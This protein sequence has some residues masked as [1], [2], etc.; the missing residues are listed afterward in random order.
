MKKIYAFFLFTAV[1]GGAIA[2]LKPRPQVPQSAQSVKVSKDAIYAN[3]AINS[4]SNNDS[5]L[6]APIP[7][8][9][10]QKNMTLWQQI[11]G[12]TNYDNQSNGSMEDRIIMD[13]NGMGHAAWMLSNE[14][15]TWSDRGTG[16]N[17]G[18]YT[19]WEVEPVDRIEDVRTGWVDLHKTANG[20]EFYVCHDGSGAPKFNSRPA[21]GT[22][23]WTLIDLPTT[24][25]QDFLW[26]RAAVDGNTIHV[27]ALSEPS[28][29]DAAALPVNNLDGNLVYWR[30]D[31]AGATWTV[32]DQ[33]FA[34]LDVSE[35]EGISS[36]SYAIDARDGVV[37]IGIFSRFHDTA[38]LK[39][40]DNGTSWT[41]TVISDFA[42]PGYIYDSLSDSNADGIADTLFTCDGTGALLID[43]AGVTHVFF[44]SNF[45]L[46]DT[47]DDTFYS[48]F[49]TFDLLYWNETYATDDVF[50]CATAQE[51]P[52]DD[53]ETFTIGSADE[54]SNY[55]R[56][57][58]GMPTITEDAD[59]V[60][61]IVY[62]GADEEYLGSQYYRHL[63]V[64][65]TEDSGASFVD[66]VE[67]TPDVDYE[68]LEFAYPSLV[69][70]DG[71]LHIVA[72]RDSE[73]GILVPEVA[74]GASTETNDI[75]YLAVTTDLNVDVNVDEN[76]APVAKMNVYPSPTT[77]VVNLEGENLD[78]QSLK[79]Y[80]MTGKLMVNTTING[81]DKV[82]YD[83]SFLP[84]G[85]Y[86]L[87]IGSGK[88]KMST[89]ILIQ[90]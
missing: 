25:T 19:N 39:S 54:V 58:A 71:V 69:E 75:I 68:Y 24:F 3:P 50:I 38:L 45:I 80:D 40:G 64:T 81:R 2:Q 26:P 44:G 83:F 28:G 61:Y 27:I 55:T 48:Y 4:P 1:A 7:M 21:I 72:Q 57:L 20:T 90:K 12:Y 5:K 49:F 11:I 31:D 29:L 52:I 17:T 35:Y 84:D 46:D 60:I 43:G 87:T 16:Y 59:G 6:G 42:I 88:S 62:A 34:E 63:Y 79:V 8:A 66:P 86:N 10:F 37:S 47:P 53:D 41:Y 78:K 67:L 18:V 82:T 14:V 77:G 32:Q 70:H 15:S 51:S 56:S 85:M 73:P 23:A 74:N 33:Y 9:K 65:K 36:D 30:S 13:D 76:A 22:G 89:E